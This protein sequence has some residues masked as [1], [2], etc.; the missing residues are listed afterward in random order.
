MSTSNKRLMSGGIYALIASGFTLILGVMQ[1]FNL[2]HGDFY[3]LGA[4]LTFV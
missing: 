3:M 2:A 1:I 4:Y